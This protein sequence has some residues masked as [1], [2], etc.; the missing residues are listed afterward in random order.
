MNNWIFM[1]TAIC[2]FGLVAGCAGTKDATKASNEQIKLAVV[3]VGQGQNAEHQFCEDGKCPNRTRKII[4]IPQKPKEEI[5]PEPAPAPA[6]VVTQ[7][8]PPQVY[9]V[10]FLWGWAKLDEDGEKEVAKVVDALRAKQV[11]QIVIAG[12]TDPTGARKFNEKLAI[13]RAESVKA[14]LVR[15]GIPAAVIETQSQTPCC[16]GDLKA[17]P[18]VMKSLRRTDIELTVVTK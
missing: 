5:K 13:R 1:T 18:S 4:A 14:A 15:S 12:R 9:T 11:K 17:A 16:D 8:L 2:S 3:Q 7:P 10:H 6:P